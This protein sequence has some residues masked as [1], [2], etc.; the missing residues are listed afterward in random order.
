MQGV[1]KAFY[2]FNVD[3]PAHRDWVKRKLTRRERYERQFRRATRAVN[4]GTPRHRQ[5]RATPQLRAPLGRDEGTMRW[6]WWARYLLVELF[7]G[8]TAPRSL[9]SQYRRHAAT[10]RIL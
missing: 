4:C 7:R 10:G 3:N 6:Q 5:A 9:H 8:D 2:G 1:V